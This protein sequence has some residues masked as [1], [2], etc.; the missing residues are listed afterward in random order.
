MQLEKAQV[1]FPVIGITKKALWFAKEREQLT[2]TTSV[3]LKKG[4]YKEMKIYDSQGVIWRIDE[5]SFLS[6]VGIF[7]GYNILGGRKIRVSLSV[8]VEN[9]GGS[10]LD[11]LKDV[12]KK[13]IKGGPI[14]DSTDNGKELCERIETFQKTSEL[15]QYFGEYWTGKSN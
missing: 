12:I 7:G 15:I 1:A 2:T 6:G 8:T 13:R 4:K 10:A 5:A 3:G 11:I 9:D 14:H